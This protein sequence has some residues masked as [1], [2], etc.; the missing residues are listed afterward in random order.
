MILGKETANFRRKKA[1]SYHSE[2]DDLLP[3]CHSCSKRESISC[4]REVSKATPFTQASLWPSMASQFLG[5]KSK[6]NSR[7]WTLA[8]SLIPP[9]FTSHSPSRQDRTFPPAQ[10]ISSCPRL[11][12]CGSCCQDS[13]SPHRASPAGP[14]CLSV[15]I[16]S[17]RNSCWTLLGLMSSLR[18][19]YTLHHIPPISCQIE[20]TCLLVCLSLLNV[21]SLE[22][23]SIG[24]SVIGHNNV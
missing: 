21:N 20:N 18:L 12:T 7:P 19:S 22:V 24:Y 3:K 6:L 8:S 11:C 4:E 15:D 16:A 13:L 9:S 1:F 17:G 5:T 2:F 10:H 23:G 14:S